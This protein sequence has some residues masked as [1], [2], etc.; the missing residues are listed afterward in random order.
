MS[1]GKIKISNCLIPII[2]ILISLT[3]IVPFLNII[4]KSLSSSN[5][6]SELRGLD[7][8]P[9]GFSFINYKVILSY[10]ILWRSLMNSIF[11]TITGTLISVLLTTLTAYVLT[12]EGLAFKKIIMTFLIIFM[13]FE[14]GDVQEYM[15][16]K[17]LNLLNNL[18]AMVLYR[19][20]NVYY[21][22]IMMRFLQEIPESLID[23]GKIDG[24]GHFTIFSKIVLPLSKIPI[25]T[26]G[27]F[28]IVSKWN[29]FF[30]SSIFL[31]S[32][33]NT[34]LQV[35]LRQLIVEGDTGSVIGFGNMMA[36]NEMARLDF[37]SIKAATIVVTIVPILMV[38]PFILRYYVSGM[39]EG[40]I[41]E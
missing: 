41:K 27:M 23:S 6:V 21:L 34:V 30:K 36:N 7:I 16:M 26:I 38:Y 13:I 29:E 22:I 20:L 24:A 12:R 5:R 10:D 17:H 4:A 32:K 28:Y 11:I 33:N 14:P 40:S 3:M 9:K 39:L 2:L 1:K 31:S 18:F 35:M 8:L 37:S 25:L 15:V 19:S